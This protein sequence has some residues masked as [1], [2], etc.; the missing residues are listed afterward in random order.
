MHNSRHMLLVTGATG[1]IGKNLIPELVKLSNIRILARRTSNIHTFKG[2][3]NLE[4]C[5]GSLE[6]IEEIAE[7]LKDI[8]I[9]IHCAARTVGKNF[10]EYYRTNTLGTK[11]LIEAV[12]QKKKKII[13]LSSYAACGISVGKTPVDETTKP[14]PISFY[15][16]S[17][18]LAEAIIKA[19]GLNFIILRPPAVYG[20]NEMELFK[21]IKL[22]NYGLC[23]IAGFGE[24]YINLI[25]IEDLVQLLVKI[26]KEGIFNNRV[27]FVSDGKCYSFS[28]VVDEIAKILNKKHLL[29]I[30]IPEPVALFC[31]LLNDLFLPEKKRFVSRD[32]VKELARECW[33][34]SNERLT[35]ELGFTPGYSLKEGMQRTINWYRKNCL[36]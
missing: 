7:A 31:G 21:Y 18:K 24:K 10:I 15:G 32:K 19:S 14:N 8:E 30:Y 1:F 27:Y 6:N 20:P 22:L 12:A 17:K 28:E 2:L 29:K 34:C 23:P 9:V 4:I 3:K 36:L 33:V 5:Y 16:L 26:I 25:Y 13:Y 11:N 35:Q